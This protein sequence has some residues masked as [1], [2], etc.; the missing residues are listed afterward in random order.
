[1]QLIFS[2]WG[3][4]L[5]DMTFIVPRFGFGAF[6]IDIY[7]FCLDGNEKVTGIVLLVY[8]WSLHASYHE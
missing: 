6:C 7:L 8:G 5:S 3:F 1:M 2:P 4:P